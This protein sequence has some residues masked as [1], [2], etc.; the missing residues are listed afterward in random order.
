MQRFTALSMVAAQA[1]TGGALL[2]A[3]TLLQQ[4]LSCNRQAHTVACPQVAQFGMFTTLTSAPMLMQ[5]AIVTSQQA[6]I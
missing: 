3:S 5:F 2:D 6:L 4:V 1:P